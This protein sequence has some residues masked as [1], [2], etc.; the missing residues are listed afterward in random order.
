MSI[1]AG[2]AMITQT[3]PTA[4]HLAAGLPDQVTIL[5]CGGTAAFLG[6][7]PFGSAVSLL[8]TG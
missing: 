6:S 2:S 3:N 7:R 5:E 8:P 4:A 1:H